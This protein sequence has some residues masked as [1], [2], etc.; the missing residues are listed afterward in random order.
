LELTLKTG[1]VGLKIRPGIELGSLTDVGC[2]RI[3]N[4]D[5]CDYWE[6][7]GH[8]VFVRKGRLAIIADGMGG[9]EGGQEASRLAVGTIEQVYRESDSSDPQSLLIEG[10]NAAHQRILQYADEHPGM[11]GMGTTCTALALV[12]A[13][14]FYAHVGDSRLYLI[15]SKK[16]SRVTR[17]HSYVNRLVEIGL[18]SSQEAENHPQRNVLTAALGAGG[19]IVPEC[20]TEPI[21]LVS[22]DILVLCTDGLWGLVTDEE[23]LSA[24]AEAPPQSACHSLVELAKE[25]GGPDNIT[26]MILRLQGQP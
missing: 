4:E 6:P 5:L 13:N 22:A 8:E 24:V 19:E 25:R 3:N 2:Q 17:D 15:R 12:G 18:I 9:Y 7:A 21:T 23:I 20:P 11:Q 26:L 1:E 14:L 10:I 16:I